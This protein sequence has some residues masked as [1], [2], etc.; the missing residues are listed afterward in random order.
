MYF[1]LVVMCS[2]RRIFRICL[3]HDHLSLYIAECVQGEFIPSI[4]HAH[5]LVHRVHR[6][7]FR[8]TQ[9]A[10]RTTSPR[11]FSHT[12]RN[13][14]TTKSAYTQNIASRLSGSRIGAGVR[15]NFLCVV[16]RAQR[17]KKRSGA[18]ETHTLYPEFRL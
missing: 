10:A 8:A 7:V 1:F 12:K 4:P 2:R 14:T 11:G 16:N 6:K 13:A 5:S 9:R 15:N 17:V 3:L 18:T